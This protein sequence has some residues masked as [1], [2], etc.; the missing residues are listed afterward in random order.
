MKIARQNWRSNDY[1]Y[2]GR[3]LKR[4][5]KPK[6]KLT[7]ELQLLKQK[8]EKSKENVLLFVV[9]GHTVLLTCLRCGWWDAHRGS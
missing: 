2:L 7:C 3:T 9:F 1:K 6:Y 4:T 8:L 5:G